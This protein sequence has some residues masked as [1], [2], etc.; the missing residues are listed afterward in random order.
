[1]NSKFILI[2][3]LSWRKVINFDRQALRDRFFGKWRKLMICHLQK[4]LRSFCP[5]LS[6][7][8]IESVHK[9]LFYEPSFVATYYC[10]ATHLRVLLYWIYLCCYPS[11]KNTNL[12]I[13]APQNKCVV[14][15][16]KTLS[17]L[18]PFPSLSGWLKLII[19][20]RYK[21]RLFDQ[22]WIWLYDPK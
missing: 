3:L 14:W 13:Y 4:F 18:H 15:Q 6:M 2:S 21:H 22:Y 5:S 7:E 16:Y 9:Y 11:Y 10:A 20:I 1:M 19:D 12:N 17:S 8:C